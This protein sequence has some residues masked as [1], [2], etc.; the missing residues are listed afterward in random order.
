MKPWLMGPML[1][2]AFLSAAWGEEPLEERLPESP[3]QATPASPDALPPIEPVAPDVPTRPMASNAPADPE[4][5]ERPLASSQEPASPAES[6]PLRSVLVPP[7]PTEP[8]T[9]PRA[10][11]VR[12]PA[13][14]AAEIVAEVWSPNASR[15]DANAGPPSALG[16]IGPTRPLPIVEGLERSGDRTRRPWIVGSYWKASAAA[17]RLTWA[18]EAS[19]HVD[20][21]APGSDPLDRAALDVIAAA[22]MAEVSA[23]TAAAIDALQE[24]ADSSRLPI[25]EPLPLPV[26]RPLATPYETQFDAIFAQRLATGRIRAIH[27]M[28][29]H[30]HDSLESTAAGLLAAETA[31]SMAEQGHARGDR[32]I[33]AVAFCLDS[34]ARERQRFLAALVG[35]NSVIAEYVGAVA[36]LSVDDARFAAMLIG[37]PLPST[38]RQ[39]ASV[40]LDPAVDQPVGQLF[41]QPQSAN[42]VQPV[43]RFVQP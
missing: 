18:V 36:D 16:S 40:G 35:Y 7:V 24:L 17:M 1:A 22:S 2:V 32:R 6:A 19:Q 34:L 10:D 29:P 3:V 13:S 14:A 21:I 33:E 20:S 37:T 12:R 28:L 42:A 31:L 39:S 9:P 11:A 25:G 8:S 41:I 38:W 15:R 27:H 26:D 23:A 5:S 4:T 43:V 30:L